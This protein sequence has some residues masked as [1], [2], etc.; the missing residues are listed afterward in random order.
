MLH[1]GVPASHREKHF[2]I[3]SRY[4]VIVVLLHHSKLFIRK[5]KFLVVS[6][7]PFPSSLGSIQLQQEVVTV[8][9]HN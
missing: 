1:W 8:H 7:K 2:K 4:L 5:L 9:I 6:Y 3:F